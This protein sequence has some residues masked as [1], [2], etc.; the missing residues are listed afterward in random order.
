MSGIFYGKEEFD[1]LLII[2]QMLCMQALFYL[3]LGLAYVLMDTLMGVPLSLDQF[4]SADVSPCAPADMQAPR[5]AVV[6]ARAA[7]HS[8][9]NAC[10]LKHM[11]MQT[12]LSAN[13]CVLFVG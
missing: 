3:G 6:E 5:L 10:V 12:P 4:F 8:S 9:A 13:A 7:A 1:A 11:R 2:A